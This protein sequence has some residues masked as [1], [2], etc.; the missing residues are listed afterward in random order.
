MTG[1]RNVVVHDYL[2]V[3]R[4][5]TY[6]NIKKHLPEKRDD[7]TRVMSEAVDFLTTNTGIASAVFAAGFVTGLKVG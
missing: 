3:D 5:I 6:K 4:R 7:E 2:K 1:Y